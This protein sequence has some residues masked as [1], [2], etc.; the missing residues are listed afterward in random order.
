MQRAYGYAYDPLNRLLQ[1]DFVARAGGAPSTTGA[2][3]AEL[4]NYRMAF[5]S[6]D[7]NGNITTLRRR[8]LLAN[9]THATAKQFG[10]VDQLTYAYAGNRLQAVDDAVRTNQLPRP[11]NYN[12]APASLAGDFQEGGTHLNQEYLYD[13]NGNL[14]QDRNKGITGIAYNHLNLPR[15]IHFGIGADSLVFRYTA[16]GQKV[17]KLVYQTGKPTQRTDYLGP[18][19]Y[20]GD[21]L[22]F[23]PH[24]EGRVLR[25]VSYDGAR[26][27]TTR[28]ERE[29]TFKDHLGNLRLAYRLGQVRTYRAGLEPA[30]APRETQQFDSLSVS[31][32]I[33]FATARAHTS[34][35]VARLTAGGAAPQPLGPLTQFAVQKGDTVRAT[36]FGLYPQATSNQS[37]AFSLAGFIASLLQPAPAGTP[38]GRDGARRGGLPLL[39]V[40]LSSATLLALNQLPGG[41]PKGYLRVLSFNEDSVLVD[42]R[43][44]QLSAAALNNYEPLQTGPLVVQQNGYVTAYVGNESNADV[45]FDDVSIEHRQ[46]LQVQENQ[47]D[48]FGLDL[49][50]VSGAAPG[51]RLKNFYQFNG[52]E[53]QSDLGLN[54]NDHGWRNYDPALGRWHVVDWLAEKATNLT[55]YRFGFNNPVRFFD[56]LGL[57][58]TTEGGYTTNDRKDIERFTTYLQAE[59]AIGGKPTIDQT[60]GFVEEEMGG[61]TGRLSN[62]SVL[63]GGFG[64]VSYRSGYKHGEWMADGKSLFKSWKGI[65]NE[66]TP[67]AKEGEALNNWSAGLNAAGMSVDVHEGLWKSAANAGGLASQTE[68]ALRLVKWAGYV[69]KGLG[70]LSATISGTKYLR[71]RTVG[72]FLIFAVDMALIGAGPIGGIASGLLEASGAKDAVGAALDERLEYDSFM[73][74]I[75]QNK[76]KP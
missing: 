48:P 73:S 62:G 50:G 36:A 6:Y 27:P 42:Q 5:V 15:L 18:F 63:A 71:K 49:A 9:A 12:G 33:A 16:G 37:F 76:A 17:A 13:A 65:Q 21:S 72:N 47:Y 25:F 10:P 20:E 67:A 54:W 24:A 55:P 59:N 60:N 56:P 8:G 32:P 4:D 53:N 35:Y 46:G 43:T 28:Y 39:Q 70:G 31:A 61:G 44:V 57:W 64:M 11:L 41:V 30:D 58:E 45:F 19:Q 29:F 74:Q 38:P 75:S 3:T 22:R 23:F 51:L 69:G 68:Q 14:T 2:W 40:G 52:K 1:G 34:G 7:D 26:Q 66:L